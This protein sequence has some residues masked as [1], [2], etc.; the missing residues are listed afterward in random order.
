[1][2]QRIHRCRAFFSG[3]LPWK[4]SPELGEFHFGKALARE[5]LV[6]IE[7]VGV[8]ICLAGLAIHDAKV[9]L[10]DPLTTQ[11]SVLHRYKQPSTWLHRARQVPRP[12]QRHP[13]CCVPRSSRGDMQRC[14]AFMTLCRCVS[15]WLIRSFC[16]YLIYKL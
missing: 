11:S 1:M 5:S 8:R 10:A 2:D 7:S 15:C 12:A 16:Q 6:P 14:L 3:N 9:E 13:R 4:H